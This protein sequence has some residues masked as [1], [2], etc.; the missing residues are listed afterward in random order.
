MLDKEQTLEVIK[1]FVTK[2]LKAP[3][4]A[5]FC[6]PEELWIKQKGNGK[7]WVG[8]EV[9][10]QNGFGALTCTDFLVVLNIKDSGT[11]I[12]GVYIGKKEISDYK[13]RTF[14]MCFTFIVIAIIVCLGY[15]A[16]TDIE[17]LL[18]FIVDLTK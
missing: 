14:S 7:Y 17:G 11:Y 15:W 10:S 18:N 5:V 9:N 1:P 16:Y 6:S 4:T 8:G 13:T 2:R 12:K 3:L